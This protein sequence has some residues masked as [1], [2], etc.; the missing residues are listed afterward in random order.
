MR[1]ILLFPV[2][3]LLFSLA[4]Q[5]EGPEDDACRAGER[6]EP[7]W[8]AREP[9]PGEPD[10]PPRRGDFHG[11]FMAPLRSTVVLIFT[12]EPREDKTE[13]RVT[14][15]DGHYGMETHFENDGQQF[16]FKTGGT[17]QAHE[18]EGKVRLAYNAEIASRGPA[19]NAMH[20]VH[21]SAI[22]TLDEA[23][24]LA[25]LGDKLLQVVAESEDEA[26]G[27]EEPEAPKAPPKKQRHK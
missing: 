2:L 10:R 5:G 4:A 25:R 13:F 16:H 20:R 1:K 8:E 26:D 17:V 24:T 21:G 18:D 15:S 7:M 14:C 22:V 23:V 11:E 6:Q 12:L 19:H 27:D 3:A 9:G